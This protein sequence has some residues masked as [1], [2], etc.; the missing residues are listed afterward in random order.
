M[1]E[2]DFAVLLIV[3]LSALISLMRGAVREIIALSGW[4]AAFLIANLYVLPVALLLP[5]EIPGPSLKLLVAFV[6]LFVGTLV[7]MGVAG[8]LLSALVK[9]AG[10]SALDRG[11]G[12]IFG[13]ARGALIVLVGVLLA[14]LTSM[15]REPFWRDAVLSRPLEQAAMDVKRYLPEGLSRRITYPRGPA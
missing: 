3:G 2:F 12:V 13:L 14:G 5:E 7:V 10:L 15:P 11:I 8:L 9:A 1:T 4:I 6:I